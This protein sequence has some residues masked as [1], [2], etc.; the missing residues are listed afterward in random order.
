MIPLQRILS[1]LSCLSLALFSG[2]ALAGTC[3]VS[4]NGLAFGAYQPLTFSG[5]LSSADVTSTATI[6]V[7]CTGIAVVA[8]YTISLGP[9]SFGPGDRISTRYL[10]NVTNGG[11]YMSYNVY[12]DAG[13]VTPWGNGATG[14]LLVGSIITIG[15]SSRSHTVYGSVPSGQNALRAGSYADTLTMILTYNP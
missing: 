8:D 5:K 15:S 4:S 2:A 1:G 7:N 11:A 13:Y 6:S 12:V 10:N 3:A 14:S 9:G